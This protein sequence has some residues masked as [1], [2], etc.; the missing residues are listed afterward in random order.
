MANNLPNE[1]IREILFSVVDV[2]DEMFQ[3][4]S[5]TS[6]FWRPSHLST[7]SVLGVCKRWMNIAT[8]LLYRVVVLRS[9]AQAYA[10]D[11]TLQNHKELGAHIKKLRVEGG[12]GAVMRTIIIS[13]LNMTHLC[14]SLKIRSSDSVKGLCSALSVTNPHS[15]VILSHPDIRTNASL[16][17]LVKELCV[18]FGKWTNLVSLPRSLVSAEA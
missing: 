11:R 6:P 9:K 5:V 18:C 2:P 10:L 8:P 7:A 14:L 1:L 15:L 4:V 16:K 17:E 3:D 12:F 13:S